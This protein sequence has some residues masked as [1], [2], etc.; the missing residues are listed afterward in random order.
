ML[1]NATRTE[2]LEKLVSVYVTRQQLPLLTKTYTGIT[3][4]DAYA[5]QKAFVQRRITA[6]HRVAG[7]KVGLTSKAMQEFAGSTEPDFSALIDD[8]FLFEES[9]ISAGDYFDPLVEI[10][11]AFVMKRALQGPRINVADVIA[12][13]DFVLPAIE[14]VDFRVARQPGLKAI[15]TITDMAACGAVILGGN[16]MRLEDIDVRRVHGA[17]IKN[18]AQEQDGYSSAVLGN[19]VASVAW[20][21]NKL[22]SFDTSFA[23]G[24]VILSGSFIRAVPVAAGDRLTARFDSDLGD[25]H[26][27]FV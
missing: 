26:L 20:L 4:E 25:V 24:D 21:A 16:P 1:D 23:A 19:P 2:I 3:D 13:T 6:G 18:D 11:I 15:D 14:L 9:D 8:M 10:E 27:N 5:I 22:H 12:A 7:Y 17:L